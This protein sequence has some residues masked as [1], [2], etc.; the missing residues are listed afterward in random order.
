MPVT[1]FMCEDEVVKCVPSML[2]FLKTRGTV[3]SCTID[4]DGISVYTK[5]I[6]SGYLS[7]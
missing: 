4:E 7:E 1:Y 3:S 6:E 5:E 2:S